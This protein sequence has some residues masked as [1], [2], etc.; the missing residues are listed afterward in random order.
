MVALCL[1]TALLATASAVSAVIL[2]FHGNLDALGL[3]ASVR[4]RTLRCFLFIRVDL[5]IRSPRQA[6][7]A[8]MSLAKKVKKLLRERKCENLTS[9]LY[10][11]KLI[12]YSQTR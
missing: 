10:P 2:I 11:L 5:C 12:P 3:S 1:I 7:S 8:S 6:A 4:Q 9:D